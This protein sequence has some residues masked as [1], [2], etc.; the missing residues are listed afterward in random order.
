MRGRHVPRSRRAGFATQGNDSGSVFFAAL[1]MA[2]ALLCGPPAARADD[3]LPGRVGRIADFGGQLYQ[4]PEDRA[5]EWVSIGLN[6]PVTSGDNLWVSGD[7]RA[8]VD[9]GGG[10]FR[11]AGE[12]NLHV[13]RLDENQIALFVAQGRVILRVRMLDP[14]ESARVDVP[15]TQILLTRPGLYRIDV[16]ADRQ[17]TVITVREGEAQVA[18]PA[19]VQQALPGQ[20]VAVSGAEASVVDVRN[21]VGQDGFDTWSASR[22]RHYERNRAQAYVSRQMVGSADLDDYGTWQTTP[23]YGPVWYPTAVADDWAPYRFGY[24]T[25]VGGWGYTWVDYAPW[26]YAPF[27]YGRWAFVGGRW[28][29][30]PGAY[31][32]RPIWAPALVGWIGGPGWGVSSGIGSPVYGWI[33][34]GWGEPYHPWWRRCSNNCWT[35]YN[36]PYAVNVTVRSSTPPARYRNV[37]MPGAVTAVNG[38]VLAERVSVANNRVR[39]PPQHLSTAPVLASAP[40]AGSGPLHVPMVRAG[41]RGTPQPASTF[42]P[43]TRRGQGAIGA[44]R[45]PQAAIPGTG[46]TRAGTNQ[47]ANPP[48]GSTNTF[49]R[50]VNP[51][52]SRTL[53]RQTPP[54][55]ALAP[56]G[57][58]ATMPEGTI[59]ADT[60]VRSAPRGASPQSS[61]P[62]VPPPTMQPPIPAPAAPAGSEARS[63]PRT[64]PP[65]PSGVPVPQSVSPPQLPMGAAAAR[66]AP[67]RQAPVERGVP[68]PPQ[69]SRGAPPATTAPVA[70]P[71]GGRPAAIPPGSTQPAPAHPTAAAQE[72]GK[73]AHEAPPAP[74]KDNPSTGA[75]PRQ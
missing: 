42:F 6:Y 57:R 44:T 62:P 36:R 66:P 47:G 59:N 3:D 4:S 21:G 54:G 61:G 46:E 43:V 37:G 35:R 68:L 31:V 70:T 10:Q 69:M 5:A 56:G 17:M 7:G 14:G 34:L 9:Y 53:S 74:T 64:A 60:P 32:P 28:G 24:W 39:V 67:Q 12:T 72:G 8:E 48:S 25:T 13:S 26:G 20:T 15:N 58:T 23:E 30:C 63:S 27:H 51:E 11:L 50:T 29:W 71:P 45:P 55:Q 16:T 19:G 75:P 52:G 49:T 73:P 65:Q 1:L 33:P 18:F 41:T 22:D 38:T 40:V 2:C